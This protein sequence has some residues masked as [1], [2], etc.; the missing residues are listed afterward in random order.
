M[1]IQ[2]GRFLDCSQGIFPFPLFQSGTIGVEL[3]FGLSSWISDFRS[4]FHESLLGPVKV[5]TPDLELANAIEQGRNLLL[6]VMG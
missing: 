1:G 5:T 3:G 6:L 4:H 2:G